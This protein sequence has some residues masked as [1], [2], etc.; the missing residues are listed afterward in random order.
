M[1]LDGSYDPESYGTD[2]EKEA[3]R[4]LT[5]YCNSMERLPK[6]LELRQTL[7][8]RSWLRLLGESW[9]LC[10]NIADY[11]DEILF[12]SPIKDMD[13]PVRAMMEKVE[14]REFL[15]FPETLI[16]YRGCYEG[17]NDDGCCWSLDRD[18][19]ASFPFLARYRQEDAKAVLLHGSV[20]KHDIIAYKNS[21][22][23]REIIIRTCDIDRIEY[24]DSE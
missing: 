16:I 18:I 8:V 23:E 22:N 14:W 17:I 19:A 12:E 21:R 15:D 4:S 11:L 24:L 9:D 5:R 6:L 1:W 7:P 10:D 3:A 2:E 20:W 13:G